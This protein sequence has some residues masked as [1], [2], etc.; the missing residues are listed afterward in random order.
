MWYEKAAEQ[1]HADAQLRCGEMYDKG[2]GT[3][4]DKALY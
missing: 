2:E 1:G 3:A 4:V